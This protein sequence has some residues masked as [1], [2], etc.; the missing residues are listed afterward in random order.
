MNNQTILDL[1]KRVGLTGEAHKKLRVLK[2]Y[3]KE[4]M[5]QITINLIN[6]EYEQMDTNKFNK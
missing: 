3:K 1:P 5:A 4:S 6:K 2:R